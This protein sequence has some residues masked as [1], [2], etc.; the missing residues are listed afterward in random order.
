MDDV[1]KKALSKKKLVGSFITKKGFMDIGNKES[2]KQASQ[3]YTR[4][5]GRGQN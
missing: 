3:E 4:R 2:Y 1:I 5:F